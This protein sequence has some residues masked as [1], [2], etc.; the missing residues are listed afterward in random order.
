MEE[1]HKAYSLAQ[2]DPTIRQTYEKLIGR[3]PETKVGLPAP[4]QK[5]R[6]QIPESCVIAEPIPCGLRIMNAGELH[7]FLLR[8]GADQE[9]VEWARDKSLAQAWSECERP[10][11][12]LWLCEKMI[13]QR[14]WPTHRQVVL[15]A[16]ACAEAVLHIFEKKY[17]R[18][19]TPRM[20]LESAR[21]WA[22]GNSSLQEVQ[23]A[24]QELK[25]LFVF[26]QLSL[27]ASNAAVS[28]HDAAAAVSPTCDGAAANAV[29]AAVAAEAWPNVFQR[30]KLRRKYADLVRKELTALQDP[31]NT[32]MAPQ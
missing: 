25:T 6:D 17:P 24:V 26:V 29:R 21:S 22:D 31:K 4:P 8:F 7:G 10:D 1:I 11:W 12:M 15:A 18:I 16:C 20:A 5:D 23:S 32:D 2:N 19:R 30:S 3:L 14:G 13:N 27:A 28:A 9:M